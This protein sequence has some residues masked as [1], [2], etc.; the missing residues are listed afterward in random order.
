MEHETLNTTSQLD[1]KSDQAGHEPNWMT[2]GDAPETGRSGEATGQG[3]GGRVG[4]AVADATG[5]A[6][7]HVQEAK[8]SAKTVLEVGRAYSQNAVNAASEKIGELKGKMDQA[9]EQGTRYVVDRPMRSVLIAAAGGAILTALFLFAM[10][11]ARRP[12]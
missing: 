9:R 5:T 11:G 6:Q 8:E 12:V 1:E 2:R 3:L 7:S 10:G 4:E